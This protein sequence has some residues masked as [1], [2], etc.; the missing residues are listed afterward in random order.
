MKNFYIKNSQGVVVR[1]GTCTD[2]DFPLQAGPG[3]TLFEGE[4]IPP[5][6]S[7]KLGTGYQ[8]DRFAEYPGIGQQLDMLWHSMNNGEIPKAAAFYDAIK[9][10]KDKYPKV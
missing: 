4:F 6:T 7:N 3:E 1:F 8:A 9:A 10:V 5:P 2:E